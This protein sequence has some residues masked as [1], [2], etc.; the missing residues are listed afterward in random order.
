MP[1][2]C[3]CTLLRVDCGNVSVCISR[4]HW[5]AYEHV[6]HHLYTE[7]NAL[8]HISSLLEVLSGDFIIGQ[9][10]LIRILCFAY[11]P[12][13]RRCRLLNVSEKGPMP[14]T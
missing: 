11:K 8:L 14:Q 9:Y 6:Y 1:L 2:L 5:V 10:S 13:N 12:P 7:D 3:R 4:L